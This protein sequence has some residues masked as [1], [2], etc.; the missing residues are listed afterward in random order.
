MGDILKKVVPGNPVL[1]QRT[2]QVFLKR[3]KHIWNRHESTCRALKD[4]DETQVCAPDSNPT[5]IERMW[6]LTYH[7]VNKPS[8]VY[9]SVLCTSGYLRI[10]LLENTV[11][12]VANMVNSYLCTHP[13]VYSGYLMVYG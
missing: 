3:T 8:L 9:R 2:I 7:V 6:K 1:V 10:M 11:M 4:M 12:R 13:P 5:I